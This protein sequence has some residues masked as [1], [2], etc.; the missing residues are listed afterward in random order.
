RSSN[1]HIPQVLPS[2]C[3]GLYLKQVLCAGLVRKSHPVVFPTQGTWS[4][5]EQSNQQLSF[6]GLPATCIYTSHKA[7]FPKS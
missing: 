2:S 1:S 7:F 6:S 4:A 3:V 5:K